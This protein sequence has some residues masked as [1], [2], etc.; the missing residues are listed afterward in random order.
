[1]N[2]LSRVNFTL[3]TITNNEL[4]AIGKLMYRYELDEMNRVKVSY[5]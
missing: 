1:M 4:R 5:I 3:P 2:D